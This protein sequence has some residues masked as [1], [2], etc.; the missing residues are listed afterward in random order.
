M[1][2]KNRKKLTINQGKMM[3]KHWKKYGKPWEHDDGLDVSGSV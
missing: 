2:W 3:A 1:N